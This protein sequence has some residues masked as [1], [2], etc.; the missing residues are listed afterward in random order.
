[1]ADLLST[2]KSV[3]SANETYN[4]LLNG[5][6]ALK[7]IDSS[8]PL[9]KSGFLQ[10]VKSY[11]STLRGLSID[12]P[13]EKEL[14]RLSV[15]SNYSNFT[16]LTK[17]QYFE[18]IAKLYV[19]KLMAATQSTLTASNPDSSEKVWLQTSFD[20]RPVVSFSYTTH[21]GEQIYYF[22]NEL[23]IPS[24]LISKLFISLKIVDALAFIKGLDISV[25]AINCKTAVQTLKNIVIGEYRNTMSAFLDDEN[26]GY[27]KLC[28][29][30]G[31]LSDELTDAF[32]KKLE[33]LGVVTR[34]V[35]IVSVKIPDN[36]R[37]LLENQ[38]F[39]LRKENDRREN[40]LN[41]E[42]EALKFYE[43]KAE[44]H[45]KHPDYEETLTEAEKDFALRRYLIKTDNEPK[46]ELIERETLKSRDV[47][48]SITEVKKIKEK[49]VMPVEPEV[50]KG[51]LTA[52]IVFG[53]LLIVGSCL[54][55]IAS[56]GGGL[57]ALGASVLI[58]G[59]VAIFKKNV[60]RKSGISADVKEK[61]DAEMAAYRAALAEYESTSNKK[62]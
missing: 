50:V 38:Y 42:R 54:T 2:E 28:S 58:L 44:I 56:V 3:T 45:S 23:K 13:K 4:Q 12:N 30:V 8:N 59:T 31:K 19:S 33:P 43:Q 62:A 26:T 60:F 48:Q 18:E 20:E 39:S 49:P 41:F 35:S 27:Y 36:T 14:I 5:K 6:K 47:D 29:N 51:G 52:F 9:E 22:D 7:N 61:Y 25:R 37:I 40:D 17:N 11:P 34:K 15:E 24:S 46:T 55:M 53:V 10:F 16:Y 57:I 21:E 32:N 1:M